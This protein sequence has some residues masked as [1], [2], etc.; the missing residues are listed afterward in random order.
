[1]QTLQRNRCQ[2]RTRPRRKDCVYATPTPGTTA[3]LDQSY[4]YD[5]LNRVL[6]ATANGVTTQYSY[7]A[8][9]NRTA[10][11]INATSYA[12]TVS[13]TSNRLTQVQDVTG[14]ASISYDAAG[15]ITNDGANT[16]T[17]SDRGRMASSTTGLG[18]INYAY[19][20]L[21]QRVSKTG[22]AGAVPTGA[23]YYV[24]DQAGNLLGEYDANQTPIYETVYLGN[25]QAAL[26]VGVMKQTGTVANNNITTDL[27]YVYADHIHTPRVIT[28]PSDNAIVWRWDTAE[29]F[30]AT[31]PDQNPNNLGTFT[32]N[33]RFPGQVFDAETGLNQNWNREYDP[34]QG[35]YRQS[36]PIGLAGGINTFSYVDGNPLSFTDPTGLVCEYS[37]S[38]RTFIC[39]NA[40]GQTYASCTGYSGNGQGL[41]NPA[42]Q[43]QP[44]VGPLPQGSYTV[45]GTTNRRG[46]NTRPLIPDPSNNMYGRSGFL[47]H[48][49]NAAMN[50][51][52]SE[53]CIIIPPQC[54]TAVPVGE[55]VVVRP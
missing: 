37:Q 27:Y 49:D 3:S 35:R 39:T 52:A 43:N 7:D 1:M 46:P 10:K 2:T 14:T 44:N 41:N 26:P 16:Y 22:P 25:N 32:Y 9:G 15:N 18:T 53:G 8:T 21:E 31:T 40:A 13:A 17:Y 51:T 6:S 33:Q 34:R 23:A 42:A 54:R 38:G 24:Y 48:G 36:D 55:T 28:R 5:N 11:T 4:T 50:N 45:G 12:N 19:N 20:A 29:V 30:G 47:L